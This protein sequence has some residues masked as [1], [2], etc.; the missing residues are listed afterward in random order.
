MA[1]IAIRGALKQSSALVQL[2]ISIVMLAATPQILNVL[3][4]RH[5]VNQEREKFSL[6]NGLRRL[7]KGLL[8]EAKLPQHLNNLSA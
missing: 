2:G 3:L 7:N 4:T 5:K 8:P 1:A 6:N